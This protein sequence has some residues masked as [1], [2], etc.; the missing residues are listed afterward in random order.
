MTTYDDTPPDDPYADGS[1]K[2]DEELHTEQSVIGAMM[3]TPRATEEVLGLLRGRDFHT[4]RH[5]LIF[6]A[7][8]ALH[9]AG[10]PT[11][12][13]AVT[14]ELIRTGELQRAGGADY[15]HQLTSVVPTA[16]NAGYYAE[17]VAQHSARRA[18][19]DIGTR[20]SANAAD[21]GVAIARALEDLRELR[22]GSRVAVDE[23]AKTLREVLDVDP[24]IDAYDWAIPG[25][26]ER[27]DRLVL[28]GAEGGG[29]STFL[30]QVAILSSAGIHPFRFSPIDPVKVLV[31]DAENSEK[32]WRRAVREMTDNAA[33]LGRRDPRDSLDLRCLTKQID[34]TRPQDLGRV[35]R[36]VD[37]S[38]PDLVLIGPL[39]KLVPRSIN[40]DDDAAPVIAA[41]D[42]VRDRD[43]ALLMEAHAGHTVSR[44]GERDLRPRG[45]SALL[46]WPE[47]GL[48]IS[49]DNDLT[50]GR[51][52]FTVSRWR[53]DRDQR[54]WPEK[55]HRRDKTNPG[56]LWPWAPTN[57]L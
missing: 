29:K 44:R 5:E 9:A 17:I 50:N 55:L 4:P 40:N 1:A 2:V 36:L 37:E 26:L 54:A 7:V 35:H 15:L 34:I 47:F 13:V 31:I 20:L 56:Q 39:Y 28:T 45:S 38:K 27:R 43:V 11:D 21:P 23:R 33:Q 48:G 8:Q 25:L 42:S 24:S 41:L 10:H 14:D 3:L 16:A 51:R 19:T 22:D 12:V 6:D 46:G 49:P 53:G 52:T 18:L 32:Q 30:R 57:S